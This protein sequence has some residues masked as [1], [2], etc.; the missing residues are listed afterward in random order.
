MKTIDA[1][2]KRRTYYEL[3]KNIDISDEKILETIEEVVELVPDA[4]DMK[5][6]KVLVV[7]GKKHDELWDLVYDVFEGNVKREKID[8]FKN[9]SGTVLFFYDN[10]IIEKMKKEYE[11]YKDNFTPWALQSNGMLQISIWNA[12]TE[13][14]LGANLQHYNPVIDQKV[15]EMFDVDQNYV[16]LGQMVYGNITG[17]TYEKDKEDIKQRVK[18][19][20]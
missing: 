2:K 10:N 3:D 11:P 20:K 5:S 6:Q 8:S 9:A 14:G 7:Q 13:L 1:L 19:A 15:K 4:F 18:L 12:L 17:P 16:L